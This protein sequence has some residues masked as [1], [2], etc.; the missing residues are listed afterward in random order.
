M[1][2]TP[3]P[4]T[5]E[6]VLSLSPLPIFRPA[7]DGM[8]AETH[9]SRL[10]DEG[11]WAY[12][13]AQ[14]ARGAL[15]ALLAESHR[16]TRHV[17]YPDNAVLPAR[18]ALFRLCGEGSVVIEQSLGQVRVLDPLLPHDEDAVLAGSPVAQGWSAACP[19]AGHA[20]VPGRVLPVGSRLPLVEERSLVLVVEADD[21]DDP[22][23]L[24]LSWTGGRPPR[25]DTRSDADARWWPADL[26]VG[27][28]EPP[29]RAGEPVHQIS[30]RLV[31]GLYESPVP[32]LGR[33][34]ISCALD[35]E[36]PVLAVGESRSEALAG[37]TMDAEC[38]TEL[39]PAGPGSWRSVHRLGLRYLRVV[40][41]R[42]SSVSIE[43]SARRF[44]RRSAF[45]CSDE[46]LTAI[47]STAATTLGTCIQT[48]LVDGI[49]RDRV[50]WMGDNASALGPNAYAFGD[51]VAARDGIEALLA[52]RRG[53]AN[54]IA[55]YSLWGVI[56]LGL[57]RE[58]FDDQGLA[59]SVMGDVEA[60]MESLLALTDDDG[61]LRT[62]KDGYAF[63]ESGPGAVFLD[64]GVGI[65]PDRT[66]TAFQALWFWALTSAIGVRRSV[67]GGPAG[68][69]PVAARWAGCR[70]RLRRALM[71]SAWDGR[72]WRE[73]V[74]GESSPAPL[75]NTLAVLAGLGHRGSEAVAEQILMT[76]SGTPSMRSWALRA[77]VELG[78]RERAL[79]ILRGLWAPMIEA[80]A[81]TF[82]EEF[83]QEGA[84]PT[85]MY[86]R[87]FGKSLCH[88]WASGPCDLL[89]RIVLGVHPLLP[90]WRE[91]EVDPLLG[92]L[93]WAAGVVP[94]PVGDVCVIVERGSARVEVP[95][96]SVLV[97]RGR[98]FPGPASVRL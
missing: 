84:S 15:R 26:R 21:A 49:K 32:V 48:L 10:D 74:D 98:R 35:A 38:S 81:A 75:A 42:V 5:R 44:G 43:A 72:A 66:P 90:G 56:A 87:P 95:A 53:F 58:F 54:G 41:D 11:A 18:R 30:P 50:P 3:P 97:H 45:A 61:L 55:D 86:G 29:H 16:T 94:S 83:G 93:G 8:R 78:E 6:E 70:T 62:V 20:P 51:A 24:R 57:D 92:D 65:D 40:G 19:E 89:P 31:D 76:E 9:L 27:D 85:E 64:W 22:P 7:E 17:S 12:P 82:W 1:T 34:V 77:L 59:A 73:Y 63:P 68:V 14:F 80:G 96:G 33:V 13:R 60:L 36:E 47:W 69:D 2:S 88:G 4:T 46:S 67:L 23:A 37:P 91:F 71:E 25:I 79:G 28:D 52:S 39:V